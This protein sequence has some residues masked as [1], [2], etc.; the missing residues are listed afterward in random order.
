MTATVFDVFTEKTFEYLTISRGE[1][2]G[3]RIVDSKVL[4]GI[5]KIKE[6]MQTQT[7][8]EV[9][10]SSSRIHAHPSDFAGLTSQQIIGN[11]VR[12]DG[13]DYTIT[14]MTEGANFDDGTIEHITLILERS[15]FTDYKIEGTNDGD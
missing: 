3:N 10:D 8:Q 1:V 14:D 4:S 13:A 6:G 9:R 12:Y 11:G 5:V 2:Y 7:N 15:D